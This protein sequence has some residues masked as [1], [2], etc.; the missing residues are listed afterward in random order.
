MDLSVGMGTDVGRMRASNEDSLFADANSERGL[1]IVA[2][3]MG[4]HAAGEVASAMAV[5]IIASELPV[6]R[7][8]ETEEPKRAVAGALRRANETIYRRTVE[9][10]EKQGMGTTASVLFLAAGRYVIG[11]IGDSRIYLLRNGQFT[12]LTKDHS[13]VQEQVDAGLLTPEQARIH[14]YSNVI[15]RCVGATADV[16]PDIE[17]G[18]FRE[19]DVFLLASDG[20]T[21]MLDDKRIDQV[22]R[23]PLSPSRLVGKLIAEANARGGAD[24]ITAIVVHVTGPSSPPVR[25]EPVGVPAHERR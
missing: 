18:E 20:L 15:T 17:D 6:N 4:G 22:L 8:I 1:F 14:P 9:E 13:Y 11:H 7:P 3:G 5:E 19:G 25:T 23:S 12:Q 10:V 16:E 21:A 24:N 2:D